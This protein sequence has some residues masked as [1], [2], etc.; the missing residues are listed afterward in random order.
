M[1]KQEKGRKGEQLARQFLEEKGYGFCAQNYR[2]G[3]AEIDLIMQHEEL[4]IFVEVKYR[5]SDAFGMPEETVSSQQQERIERAALAYVEEINWQKDIRFDI[6]AI[7]QKGTQAP[8]LMHF[9]DAF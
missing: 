4:L 8:E 7:L 1:Q 3:R 2:A 6:V 5:S 9:E